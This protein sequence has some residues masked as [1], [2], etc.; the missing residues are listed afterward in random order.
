[1]A[2]KYEIVGAVESMEITDH[3][4]AIYR[5]DQ[6]SATIHTFERDGEHDY[7]ASCRSLDPILFG[8]HHQTITMKTI[9]MDPQWSDN[10]RKCCIGKHV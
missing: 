8:D 5:P 6:T 10:Q 4:E 3:D 9:F 7:R 1:M 2:G